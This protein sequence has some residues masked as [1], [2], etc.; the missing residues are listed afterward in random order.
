MRVEWLGYLATAIVITT[1]L[2]QLAKVVRTR[3]T[4]GLSL[5][6]YVLIALGSGLYIPYAVAIR[7]IP[8]AVTNIV[9]AACALTIL[10]YIVHDRAH[11]AR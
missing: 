4:E 2:P 9:L 8:V 7:S 10:G 11:G 1:Q 3:D 6:T 5:W